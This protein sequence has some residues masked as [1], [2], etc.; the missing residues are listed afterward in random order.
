MKAFL[1]QMMDLYFI[2]RFIKGR[3][4]NVGRNEKVMKA[5]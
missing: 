1:V 4:I 3:P 2:F 5:D